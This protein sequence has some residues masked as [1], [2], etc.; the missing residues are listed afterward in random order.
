MAKSS[1]NR[2]QPSVV[3]L[4]RSSRTQCPVS[5][6]TTTVTSVATSLICWLSTSPNDY[7]PPITRTG[8]V[9]WV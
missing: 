1:E 7:S 6:N 4:G 8:I 5:F 2:H 3:S 9:S